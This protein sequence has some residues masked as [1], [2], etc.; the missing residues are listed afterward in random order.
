MTG[1]GL[2]SPA[3]ATGATPFFAA[4]LPLLP[5][6]GLPVTVTVGGGPAVI[7]FAGIPSGLAGETQGNFVIPAIVRV[8]VQRVFATVDAALIF[9]ADSTTAPGVPDRYL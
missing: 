1:E 8:G 4:P 2:V 5:Q 9:V 6:P 3:L 7:A